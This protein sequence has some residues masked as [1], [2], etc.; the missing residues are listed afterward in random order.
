MT[1]SVLLATATSFVA[2]VG[3]QAADQ[4]PTKAKPVQYVRVCPLY[5]DGF[6][7]I[8]GTETC[9]KI[10]GKIQEDVGWNVTGARSPNYF[11]LGGSQ[12]RTST[13]LSTRGR[14]DIAFD[15]RS[16]TQYGVVR[17]VGLMHFQNQDA[18]ESMNTARAFIQ[19]SGWTFGRIKSYQDTFALNDSWNIEQ[20]QTNSDTGANGVQSIAYTADFGGGVTLDFGVDDRR[21]KPLINLSSTAALKIGAEPVDSH[22]SQSYPD[23]Y[24]ALHIDETWGFVAATGGIHNVNASYYSGDGVAGGPFAAFHSCGAPAAPTTQCGHPSDAVGYFGAIG[25][26]LKLPALGPGDKIGWGAKYSVGATQFG[27]GSQL[28]SPALFGSGNTAALGFSSDGVF[29]N[30]SGIELTTAMGLQG[31]Y[32]HYW[33]PTL[34]TD[35]FVGYSKISYDSTAQSYFAGAL[36]CVVPTN[37]AAHQ[38]SLSLSKTANDCNPNWAYMELGSRTTWTPF[39]DLQISAQIMYN[40]VWS[41]FNGA[42]TLLAA[43]SVGARPF[44]AANPYIL[45]NQAIWTGYFRIARTYS[46]ATE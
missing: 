26:E 22:A 30:G 36:Q 14:V 9:I 24:V 39:P 18:A 5:G 40:K 42:A 21:T 4:M 16:N 27:A 20:G 3:A 1:R 8:P 19:W 6:Y 13:Q 29:V 2:L 31:G 35:L 10:G 44:G 28:A 12:D 33:M 38:A 34:S 32:M 17:S 11:A 41:G 7:Y 23:S 25:G 43:P 37:G 15:T 45:G 46:S